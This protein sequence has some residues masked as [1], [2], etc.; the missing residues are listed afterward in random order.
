MAQHQNGQLLTLA[1]LIMTVGAFIIG[2]ML[3][4]LNAS[5]LL[6]AKSEERAITYY[7]ADSGFEYAVF[8]LQGGQELE[9]W[10][11]TE[12]KKWERE[13]YEINGRTVDV[14]IEDMGDNIYKVTSRAY[15]ADG[16]NTIIESYVKIETEDI[17]LYASN[18]LVS[19]GDMKGGSDTY[20]E[21]GVI[22]T[23]DLDIG[24]NWQGDYPEPVPEIPDW[25]VA[26]DLI[27]FYLQDVDVSDPYPDD[28][29]SITEDT[30][31]GP[32]Y[33]SGD[34]LEIK[35]DVDDVTLTLTGTIY[36]QGEVVFNFGNAD[37]WIDLNGQTIFAEGTT[38]NP[39]ISVT[40]GSQLDGSG[41]ILA[42]G[43]DIYIASDV[44][45]EFGDPDDPNYILCMAV[46]GKLDMQS[47]STWHG[48]LA[49]NTVITVQ[50]NGS[51]V[52]TGYSDINFPYAGTG[53][54]EILTYNIID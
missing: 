26:Q 44:S 34:K 11:E 45:T 3:H 46:D 51:F 42:T 12:E 4:Y 54:P 29:I 21:G 50:S 48:S 9:G 43:G 31:L 27:D 22:Y 35:A 6:A 20:V 36:V 47:T 7:A 23:G 52:Y 17:P 10:N 30:E 32:L 33:W 49:G 5:L 37:C 28:V 19:N 24:D 2:A 1:L 53:T 14:S 25:P 8:W 16:A 40:S 18:A 39:A 13:P 41:A 15:P 38:D